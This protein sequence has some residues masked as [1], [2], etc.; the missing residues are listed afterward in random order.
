M[1]T[2]RKIAMQIIKQRKMLINKGYS[3]KNVL[4]CMQAI[5]TL[6]IQIDA[7]GNKWNESGWKSFVARN[8]ELFHFLIPENKAGQTIKN[9]LDASI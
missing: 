7:Y 4:K 5:K 9:K 2:T 1:D 3:N 6:S 8:I